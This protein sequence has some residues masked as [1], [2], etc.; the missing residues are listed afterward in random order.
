[1]YFHISILQHHWKFLRFA[2]V[3]EAYKYQVIPFSLPLSP[4]TF[5]KCVDAA[6]APL[7]LQVIRVL[8]C[9]DSWLILAHSEHLVIQSGYFCISG[10]DRLSAVVLSSASSTTGTGC[11]GADVAEAPLSSGESLSGGCPPVVSGFSLAN[12]SVV[13]GP[14]FPP[15][16]LLLG[17]SDQEGPSIS[18]RGLNISLPPRIL[19]AVGT[20]VSS[21]AL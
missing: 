14:D 10:N 20:Y 1:M 7:R 18:G 5:T 4:H 19:E 15:L 11:H 12:S 3:G 2:F 6:L 17:D 16:W 21:V 13:L 9:I 8:N